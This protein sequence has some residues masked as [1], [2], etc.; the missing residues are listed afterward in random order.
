MT[1]DRT[2][3]TRIRQVLASTGPIVDP[4]GYATGALKD[5]IGYEGSPV[6]FIQ[7]IA[8]MERDG[9]IV[10]DIRGKRTYGITAS[11]STIESQ[12]AQ[13]PTPVRIVRA[14]EVEGIPIDYDLLARSIVRELLSVFATRQTQTAS[15]EFAERQ[16]SDYTRRLDEAREKLDAL[17]GEA[18]QLSTEYSG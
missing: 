16:Q 2:A 7:L 18:A 5:L 10:R 14:E 4:S 1:R 12:L 9:E 3:R 6:A 15:V 11:A 13:T 8:A 17:L